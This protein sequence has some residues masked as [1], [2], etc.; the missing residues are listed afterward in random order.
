MLAYRRRMATTGGVIDKPAMSTP[1]LVFPE[2]AY[3]WRRWAARVVHGG[4]VVTTKE[5]EA[6]YAAL[7]EC[8]RRKDMAKL[9]H[10]TG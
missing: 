3:E 10:P 9:R 4:P 2:V 8:R 7:L 1:R 6:L 5:I